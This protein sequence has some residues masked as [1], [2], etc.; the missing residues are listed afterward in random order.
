MSVFGEVAMRSL[1]TTGDHLRGSVRYAIPANS[2]VVVSTLRV[3]F[4]MAPPKLSFAKYFSLTS[5]VTSSRV[6]T[7]SSSHRNG[8]ALV[9]GRYVPGDSFNSVWLSA[10]SHVGSRFA[11]LR[12][13]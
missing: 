13:P 2:A 6:L 3:P 4:R 12:L 10:K 9:P 8:S 11:T 5:Q 7:P 1:D